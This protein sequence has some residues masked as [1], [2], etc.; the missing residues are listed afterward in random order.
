MRFDIEEAD[1]VKLAGERPAIIQLLA[2]VRTSCSP[3]DLY[4]SLNKDCAY[5]L[6]SV[7]KEKKHARFSFVGAEPDAIVTIKNRNVSLEYVTRTN[8]VEF[9]TS[10]L[11][12]VCE[13]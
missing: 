10:S 7:E 9:I 6:E 12:K 4:A 3:L 11:S 5:L 1:F 2:K 13:L 8:L